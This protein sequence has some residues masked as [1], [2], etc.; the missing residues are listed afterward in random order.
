[1]A[2]TEMFKRNIYV[3][4]TVLVFFQAERRFSELY[5]DEEQ[6]DWFF[7]KRFKMKLHD[8]QVW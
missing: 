5:E 4:V 1:M 8:L 7:F 3:H 6:K 2:D